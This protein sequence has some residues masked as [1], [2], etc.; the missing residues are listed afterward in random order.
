MFAVSRNV[1]GIFGLFCLAAGS[2]SV[3]FVRYLLNKVNNINYEIH[4]AEVNSDCAI[5]TK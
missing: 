3:E 1:C 4:A 2:L 5:Q